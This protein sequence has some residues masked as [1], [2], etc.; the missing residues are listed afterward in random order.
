MIR[1]IGNR[2][3]AEIGLTGHRADGCEFGTDRFDRVVT[4]RV[5][6]VEDFKDLAEIVATGHLCVSQAEWEN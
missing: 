4:V 6:V 3:R 2:Q 1:N 5:R